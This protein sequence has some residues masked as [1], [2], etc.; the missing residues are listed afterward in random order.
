MVELVTFGEAMLRLSPP[1]GERLETAGELR[2]RVGGAESNVA[3]AGARLGLETAWLSKLPDSPLGRRVQTALRKHGTDPRIVWAEEGRQGTYYLE[4]GARPRASRVV[5][6]RENTPIQTAR[7]EELDT[8]AIERAECF[9]TTGITPA[10]SE[11][12]FETTESL[13]GTETLTAFDLNYREKLWTAAEAKRAY[14]ELLPAVDLLFAPERDVR[15]VLG[16]E[17]EPEALAMRLRERFDCETVVLTRGPDGALARTREETVE[18]SAVSAETVDPVGTGDAFVG[19]YLS[20]ALSGASV[21]RSLAY[22]AATAALKRT[23]AG[24]AAVVT[25]SDVEAVLEEKTAEIQR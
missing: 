20:R 25:Q 2:C 3:V 4:R 10:L 8:D 18:Q 11:R 9:L 5:Y 23:I 16:Y 22:G 24:D 13:L 21:A 14:E 1:A 7:P 6:D 17:G 19:G 12:L 15:S